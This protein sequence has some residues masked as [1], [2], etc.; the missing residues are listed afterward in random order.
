MHGL[1]SRQGVLAEK[2]GH[3]VPVDPS[4]AAAAREPLSPRLDHLEAEAG[5]PSTVPGPAIVGAVAPDDAGKM[6]A[7]GGQRSVAMPSA[8]VPQEVSERTKP[9]MPRRRNGI[10]F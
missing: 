7:L 6:L 8:P 5:Q 2:R 3:L 1:G 9:T 4:R 10:D